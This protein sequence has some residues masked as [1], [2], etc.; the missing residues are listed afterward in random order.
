MRSGLALAA[1]L[2]T[3]PGIAAGD[4]PRPPAVEVRLGFETFR[5]ALGS[6]G[7]WTEVAP[8]G[9][10]WRPHGVPAGWRPYWNGTWLYSDEG[11]FFASEEPWAWATY[12]YGRWYLDP[13]YDWVWV[14]GYSWAPAWVAWRLGSGVVGWAPLYPGFTSWWT[15]LY[16][17]HDE[18]WAFA[19]LSR[20]AGAAT[21][22]S[23]YPAEHIPGLL[24][25][26]RAAPPQVDASPPLGGPTREAV[27]RALG[28][29]LVPLRLEPATSPDAARGAPQDGVVPV[30]RPRAQPAVQGRLPDSPRLHPPPR[31]RP[32]PLP[33]A[34][35]GGP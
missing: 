34:P 16:P 20:F 6:L 8:Y 30:F 5:A 7:D 21:A 22:A 4:E 1:I 14:P 28:R 29:P 9:R 35:A 33:E 2:S 26:T 25:R 27:E 17:V 32:A 24:R 13:V 15:R 3:F 23:A 18:D 12:H 19:P 31:A 10:V 11:W